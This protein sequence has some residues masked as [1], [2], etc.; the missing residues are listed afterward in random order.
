[1]PVLD[2]TVILDDTVNSDGEGSEDEYQDAPEP[3]EDEDLFS[4]TDIVTRA[5]ITPLLPDDFGDEA[6]AGIKASYFNV[7]HRGET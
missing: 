4:Q 7:I 6:L 3:M 2:D 1:M 5:G